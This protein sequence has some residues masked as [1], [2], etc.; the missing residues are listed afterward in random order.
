MNNKTK[1]SPAQIFK[2]NEAI[3]NY[4]AGLGE[5]GLFDQSKKNERFFIGDQWRGA[6]VSKDRPLS[7]Y[8]IIK[9]IGEYKISVIGSSPIAVR[10]SASGVPNTV[11]INRKYDD[12]KDD[13]FGEGQTVA[14]GE[15]NVEMTEDERIA[16]IT[17]QQF[18][19]LDEN[20]KIG[21]IMDALSDYFKVTSERVKFNDKAMNALKNAYISGTAIIYTYWD[22][23]I[24]TGLYADELQTTAINGDIAVE[25]L[26]VENVQFGD[27]NGSDVQKQPFI[28]ISQRKSVD[29]LRREAKANGMPDDEVEKIKPD[30]DNDMTVEYADE[31]TESKKATVLTKMF[32][33]ENAD[34]SVT[35]H[36]VKVTKTAVVRDEFDM[37]IRLY[38]IAIMPWEK[39]KN[40]I[41]GES[42]ITYLIPNQICINR[43]LTAQTWAVL[44]T[45]M[46]MMVVNDDIV[47]DPVTNN[48][49]Q[50]LRVSGDRNDIASAVQ[51]VSPPAFSPNFDNSITSLMQNT[52]TM[53]G[54]NDAALGD[55]KAENTSAIIA[56]REAATMPMQTYQNRYYQF[57][58][59]VA[60]I[61]AEFW[62]FLYGERSIKIE[63][64]GGA[65]YIPF[66]GED[67]QKLVLS[68]VVDVGASTL[69]SESQSVSTLNNLFTAGAIDIVQF[70]ERLPKGIVPELTKLIKEKKQEIE[71]QK[72]LQEAQMQAELLSQ[73]Q[74]VVPD[75]EGILS[76]LTEEEREMFMQLPEEKQIEM[77]QNAQNAGGAVQ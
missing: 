45:G 38:P 20:E 39:R 65:V 29:E 24:K 18:D 57:V 21:F 23:E 75:V 51:F 10:F 22:S 28:I 35:V 56:V 54:A 64:A 63:D 73:Q 66:N 13:I 31:I 3:V 41:Y 14:D 27:V 48:P 8:N 46:P 11:G 33:A 26:D 70:L 37:K 52:M 62:I 67:Y 58:E 19:S 5:R 61:W 16:Q 72:Q 7:R 4:K 59:D 9:R 42:E 74:P 12:F 44:Q 55:M 2:E 34:G 76:G 47:K 68:V 1:I 71:E 77:I 40:S 60:R 32:K 17:N 69:W 50:V 15:Q 6:N 30:S 25:V 43:M 53:S 49:G 36:C